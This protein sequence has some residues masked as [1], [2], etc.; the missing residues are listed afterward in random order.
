MK[1]YVY[2]VTMPAKHYYDDGYEH[3]EYDVVNN[4]DGIDEKSVL[5]TFRNFY[6][7]L[8]WGAEPTRY[9]SKPAIK[10]LVE[11]FGYKLTHTRELGIN[12]EH[13]FMKLTI[14]TNA[15]GSH[16][17]TILDCVKNDV[18]SQTSGGFDGHV[19]AAGYNL[20]GWQNFNPV[21]I[22]DCAHTRSTRCMITTDKDGTIVEVRECRKCKKLFKRPVR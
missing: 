20:C 15:L 4:P 8:G 2:L 18:V 17:L 3:Y 1:D 14:K 12:T 11:S 19:M 10:D 16:L 21:D 22:V 13:V 9:I 5:K 6:G 7:S